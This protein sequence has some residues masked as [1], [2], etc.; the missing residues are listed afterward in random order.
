MYFDKPSYM[1]KDY[2]DSLSNL[3]KKNEYYADFEVIL[4]TSDRHYTLTFNSGKLTL[5]DESN[6]IVLSRYIDALEE[7]DP[8]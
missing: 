2:F 6:N 5:I 4:I 8:K 3:I 7:I 1:R